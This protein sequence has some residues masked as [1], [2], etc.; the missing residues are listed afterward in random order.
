[1]SL[2]K[3]AA[4]AYSTGALTTTWRPPTSLR[5]IVQVALRWTDVDL[6]VLRRVARVRPT[7][8]ATRA[9]LKDVS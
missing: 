2:L 5:L 6:V 3:A 8:P 4:Y 1:M 7:V 9:P